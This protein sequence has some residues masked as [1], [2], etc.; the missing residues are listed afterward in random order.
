MKWPLQFRANLGYG[1]KSE[2]RKRLAAGE[3]TRSIARD[4]DVDAGT[5]GRL[6][7]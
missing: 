6:K 4:F 5:V 7:R 2:A 1:Q 3:S